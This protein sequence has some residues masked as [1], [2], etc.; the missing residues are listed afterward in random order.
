MMEIAL[1]AVLLAQF[2]LCVPLTVWAVRN[3]QGYLLYAAMAWASGGALLMM[4]LTGWLP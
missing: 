4:L 1:P 2:C 3:R